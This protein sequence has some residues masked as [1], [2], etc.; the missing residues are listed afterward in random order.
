MLQKFDAWLDEYREIAFDLIR[1]YLGIGLFARGILFLFDASTLVALL[2]EGAPA[3]LSESWVHLFVAGFHMVGGL[4]I[5][6]GF[7]TRIAALSQVPI[8]FGAVFLS[9][10]SLFSA[11][12]SLELSSLV[13]FM[14]L[15]VVICGS[16][17]WSLDRLIGSSPN[18]LRQVLARLYRFRAHAFDLLRMYLGLGLLIRG[19]LFIADA[20]SF[21][22]LVGAN[23]S[24]ML[25]ST[26]L[27]H[28]VAMSHLLGGFMLLTGLL[29]RIGAL[30]QIPVLVGAVFVEEMAGGLTAGTQGFEIA[31][32]TLFLLIL[33]FLYG[34]G[35]ISS[36]HYFFK[37]TSGPRPTRTAVTGQAAEI[38]LQDVPEDR[39][40]ANPVD[41]LKVPEALTSEE[42][43]REIISNPYI[44][45][46]A[47]Y[48]FWGWALFLMD[49]TP[50]PKEIVFRDVH[51]GQILRRSKDPN[52]IKQF[53]YR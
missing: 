13:L 21:M 9:L 51:S 26:V 41:I 33:I 5:T 1:I 50:Q 46:Q 49:V 39:E 17:D 53:R 34:S 24:A 37:R 48:S 22:D 15:L 20:N 6:A 7:W 52:V 19:M 8:L 43:I 2:P 36:D 38:L 42:S 29:S 28:Y 31:M 30:I 4:L 25:R 27:L 3:W 23:S 44:V 18:D 47:R 32:L 10:G 12:Q 40:F 11:N 35:K 16:G 14:L 45:S